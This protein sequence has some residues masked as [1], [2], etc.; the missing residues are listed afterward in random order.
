MAEASRRAAAR[1]SRG[2]HPNVVFVATGVEH[3][4]PA[5]DGLADRVTV[6]FPWGSLLRGALGLDAPVAA[7]IA[8][9]VA[10]DGRLGIVLS[11]VERDGPA[12]GHGAFGGQDVERMA[13]VYG[14]LGLDLTEARRLTPDEV[15]ATGSTWAR[16]L[17]TSD[18]PVW[19]IG[20]H[21]AAPVARTAGGPPT[22]TPVGYPRIERMQGG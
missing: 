1:P 20:L 15:R 22:S 18:R 16:R 11:I 17:R 14:E 9:L 10:P 2:G 21:R 3:V 12:V 5:L 7:A 13:A 19:G 6:G 8:R 4:S